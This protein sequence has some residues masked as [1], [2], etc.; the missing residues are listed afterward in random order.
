MDE[1][2]YGIRTPAECGSVERPYAI[3]LHGTS[4]TSKL[5]PESNWTAL[6]EHLKTMEIASVLPWGNAEERERSDRLAVQI[7]GAVVPSALSL[8]QAAAL[9]A[10][11]EI[12]IGVDTGLAHLA[13][14][15][16]RPVV[17]IY[18][19]TDPK[20]TGIYAPGSNLNLGGSGHVPR[21]AEAIA[22][23][24]RLLRRA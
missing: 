22:A 8:S 24:E 3:L 19:S 17:G 14:A 16:K 12:V 1:L 10:H 15:L 20:L 18:C 23:V 13:A 21:P 11:A 4:R 6:G 7:G 9:L 5:W 2:D